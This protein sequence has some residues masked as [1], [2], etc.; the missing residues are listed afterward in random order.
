[1]QAPQKYNL[2][3]WNSPFKK[4]QFGDCECS[5][6]LQ[7]EALCCLTLRLKSGHRSSEKFGFVLSLGRTIH[8]LPPRKT[9]LPLRSESV[10]DFFARVM[11]VLT[12]WQIEV[13]FD[14]RPNELPDRTPFALD[15]DHRVYN[16]D[17]MQ[18]MWQA[19]VHTNNVFKKFRS[20]FVGKCSPSHLFWGS[21]DLAVTRFSGRRA[22]EHPG[23]IPNLPD[24]VAREA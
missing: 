6:G 1:M 21:F 20:K 23:G 4:G 14:P 10:A 18:T 2:S 5:F 16:P 12:D 19:F 7:I 15:V 17:H 8:G 3:L 11:M 22:P 9:Q 24:K 13:N